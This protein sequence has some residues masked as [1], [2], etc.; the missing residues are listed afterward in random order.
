MKRSAGVARVREDHEAIRAAADA[1]PA[2][3]AR[4]RA[5]GRRLYDHVRFEERVLFSL[6]EQRLDADALERLGRSVAA[7][8][9]ASL[10][11][12][13]SSRGFHS[14]MPASGDI[15]VEPTDVVHR[16]PS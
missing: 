16:D 6:L 3:V 1:P 10:P 12:R 11:V 13:A 15:L 9:R 5:L 8:E 2:G 7:A 14:P 4:T